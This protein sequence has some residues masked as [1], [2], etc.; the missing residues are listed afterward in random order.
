MSVNFVFPPHMLNNIIH[1]SNKCHNCVCF[2]LFHAQNNVAGQP[3]KTFVDRI[4]FLIVVNAI[5]ADTG[6]HSKS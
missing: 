6:D 5:F 3:Y 1:Q 2:L 4:P